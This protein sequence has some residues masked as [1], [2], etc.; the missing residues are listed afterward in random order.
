MS[1]HDE[2]HDQ[3]QERQEPQEHQDN[4]SMEVTPAEYGVEGEEDVAQD[5][6]EP[7]QQDLGEEGEGSQ[8]E[9]PN[10]KADGDLDMDLFGSDGD[11]DG[12]PVAE[13]KKSNK[14]VDDDESDEDEEDKARKERKKARKERK[15]EK[16]DKKKREK[17]SGS[18][19]HDREEEDEGSEGGSQ[20]EKAPSSKKKRADPHALD[21]EYGPRSL[22]LC[23]SLQT[24]TAPRPLFLIHSCSDERDE[25]EEERPPPKV[26]GPPISVTV[27]T[28]PT[29]KEGE[30]DPS[31]HFFKVP[32]SLE[33]EKAGFD[34]KKYE[35]KV[36]DA[37]RDNPDLAKELSKTAGSRIRWMVN[38]DGNAVSNAAF[39]RW[40]DGS[41]GFKVGD[42]YYEVNVEGIAKDHRVCCAPF[43]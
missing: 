35:K 25:A 9:V 3:D 36:R 20:R 2:D 24:L 40:N 14:V 21:L 8:K 39:I 6:S 26:V 30:G 38:E 43:S 27:P 13:R 22:S 11:E 28:L 7:Q 17:G 4:V 16:K 42:D 32:P 23:P 33:I 31:V 5:Q 18:E 34:P 37:E 1:D 29:P 19:D 15:K 41:M 12:S 10:T